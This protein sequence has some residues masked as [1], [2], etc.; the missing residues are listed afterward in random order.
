MKHDLQAFSRDI[1]TLIKMSGDTGGGQIRE[2]PAAQRLF[3]PHSR[4]DRVPT[5][6]RVGTAPCNEWGQKTSE[7]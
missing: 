1:V 5:Q 4:D 2:V 3:C 7:I 6:K